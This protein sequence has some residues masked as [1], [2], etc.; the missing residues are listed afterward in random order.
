M[1]T[2]EE[3]KKLDFTNLEVLENITDEERQ[4]IQSHFAEEHRIE[5]EMHDK[6]AQ[7]TRDKLSKILSTEDFE[8]YKFR[9]NKY[10]E[11]IA[12]N[13]FCHDEE[14]EMYV[15]ELY[16]KYKINFYE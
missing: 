12:G 11:S 16:K 7:E 3:L 10:E 14:W 9:E 2:F 8:E 4:L 15:Y 1:R 13:Y 5:Q 6:A